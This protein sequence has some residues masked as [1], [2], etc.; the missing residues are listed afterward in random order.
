MSNTILDFTEQNGLVLC[1]N[2]EGAKNNA[3]ILYVSE[4]KKMKAHAV[5]FRRYYKDNETIP[6]NSEPVV[7]IFKEE[8]V[9]FG[10]SAHTKLH[11]SLWSAGKN[12]VYIIQ[13]NTRIDIINARKPAQVD[14]DKKT[15]INDDLILASNA[16]KAFNEQQFSSYL[17]GSGTFWE[18]T[19]YANKIDEKSSPYIYLLD[20]LMKVRRRFINSPNIQLAPSTIDKLLIVCILVKFLEDIKDDNGKHTLQEIYKKHKVET[21]AEAVENGLCIDILKDLANEFNGKIFD[22]FSTEEK[23]TIKN[24]PLTLLSQFLNAKMDVETGQ[25]FIWEQYSFK[26]LPAEVISA[27]YEKFIQEE[28]KRQNN[29]AIE[30]GV[31]YTPIHLVNFLIDEVMPLNR[32]DL[33]QTE[34][35]KILDPSCGSGVFLVAAY[36]RLLQWWAINNSTPDNIQYPDSKKAQK[37]LEDNIY[38]VDVKE[39]AVLVSIF[40]LT[41]ALLDKLTPKQIWNNLKFEDLSQKNIQRNNFFKWASIAKEEG[42]IFDL[43]IGNPPFN[44]ENGEKKEDV[45]SSELLDSIDFKHKVIPNNNFALHFF[46]G[47]M[48][49]SKKS[50]MVIPSNVLLYNKSSVT[51][52][53][54]TDLFTDFTVNK[55]YDFTHLRESLFTRKTQKGEGTKKKTGRTPVVVLIAENTPSIGKPIQHIIIKRTV[56]TEKSIRFEID[57]YDCH[58]VRWN[59]AT[60]ENKQFVW[61]TNLL[62]G[63][64]LFHLVYRLSLLQTLQSFINKNKEY[65]WKEV[66]GFEG[67]VGIKMENQDRI[68]GI[69]S[70]SEPEVLIDTDIETSNIKDEF[71]Y[72]PPFMIFDQV[73]GSNSLP[74][75]FVPKINTYTTKKFLYYN[76]DFVGISV[77]E[78]QEHTLRKIY[79]QFNISRNSNLLNYK[80]FVMSKSSSCLVLTETDI[81]KSEILDVPYSDNHED[82]Q[83]SNSEKIIQDDVLKYYIH[84][85]KAIFKKADGAI[86]H[87]TV[88]MVQ[89]KEYG[90]IFCDTLNEIYAKNNNLWQTGKIY[91]NSL[92]SII[93]FGFGV[94]GGLKADYL[95]E[96]DD[97]IKHLMKEKFANSGAIYTRVIR[98]Y[99]HIDGYDCVFFIKPHAIRYWLKSIALRDADDIFMKL[100]KEGF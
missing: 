25:L 35:F 73:L 88:N 56:A 75:C 97:E 36:K 1:Q 95:D 51:H 86:L 71:M 61:K 13:G 10:S 2:I 46:E 44:V 4:V 31:V 27:I 55:I 63:G 50:C 37:I 76:R 78:T 69:N 90:N 42:Q 70:F 93:Q 32:A 77:P 62:G 99:K 58:S 53:Y 67:G 33:F 81:N 100:K 85:G 14:K 66:R 20:Y 34:S 92:Y 74:V 52:K 43:V 47:A 48:A 40:G 68:I 57:D 28:A 26:H 16:L 38:G 84:L 29:N 79:T 60:D 96:L 21:F 6:Y 7:C 19:E 23:K 83:L 98:L 54:R 45:L 18:Q 80:F 49:L 24:S 3:E 65:N 89:L 15:Y 72:E 59:W 91:Q 5:F 30:K 11:A 87:K 39:M 94:N 82:L 41:T 17:F 9:S 8:D 64:R 12:E 22:K